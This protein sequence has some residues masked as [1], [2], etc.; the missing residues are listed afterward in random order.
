M[1]PTTTSAQELHA[2]LTSFPN[3]QAA[4]LSELGMGLGAGLQQAAAARLVLNPDTLP[5]WLATSPERLQTAE[6]AGR[7]F[8][9]SAT[10]LFRVLGRGLIPAAWT[11]PPPE[12]G[13]PE[14]LKVFEVGAR[15]LK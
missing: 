3:R 9:S 4:A 8:L 6:A 11:V 7:A 5:L 13:L 14:L 1:A 15:Q 10:L 2:A 12:A